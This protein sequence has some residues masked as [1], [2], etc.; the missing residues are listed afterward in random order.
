MDL[1]RRARERLEDGQGTLPDRSFWT[2]LGDVGRGS[3]GDAGERAAPDPRV[4][5]V[6]QFRVARKLDQLLLPRL[7]NGEVTHPDLGHAFQPR[8]DKEVNLVP[9]VLDTD[10]D[11]APLDHEPEETQL[12]RIVEKLETQDRFRRRQV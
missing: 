10:V 12:G 6:R 8:A 9:R 4:Y 7:G 2:R 3:H 5:A 11:V 1:R